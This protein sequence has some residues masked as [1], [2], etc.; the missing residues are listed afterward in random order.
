MPYD[1]AVAGHIV[2]GSAAILVYWLTLLAKKGGPR[3]RMTGKVF[4]GVLV[5]V[6][7]SVGPVLFLRP[8]SFDPATVIQFVYLALCLMTVAMVGWTAIR[9]KGDLARFRGPHF[10]TLGA[11]IFVLG[12]VVLAAGVAQA[13]PV[14]M[15]FALIGLVYGAAMI[16]FSWMRVEPHPR[17]SMIWH[18]NATCGLFNA[19]HGTFLA[20]AWRHLADPAAADGTTIVAQLGTMAVALMMRLWFGRQR[21]A[22]LRLSRP[23][24]AA[25]AAMA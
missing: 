9:W 16:R 5:A 6:T 23:R 22:P 19:V 4:L 14:P 10:K 17:W 12:L 8:G 11:T 15:V 24:V 18:L 1:L 7:F 25:N 2:I 20:V 21:N 13:K 3:H